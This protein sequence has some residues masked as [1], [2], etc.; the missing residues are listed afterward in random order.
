LRVRRWGDPIPTT[1]QKAWYSVSSVLYTVLSGHRSV[2]VM[3]RMEWNHPFC[4]K[5]PFKWGGG[6]EGDGGEGKLDTAHLFL[7]FLR[8]EEGEAPWL[9]ST[10]N[11]QIGRSCFLV[12]V[13]SWRALGR[14]TE[15]EGRNIGKDAIRK[16]EK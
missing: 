3:L 4:P 16:M 13:L 8:L 2:T 10:L 9:F 5:L 12:V 15:A 7:Y 14:I 1:G 11:V 6:G